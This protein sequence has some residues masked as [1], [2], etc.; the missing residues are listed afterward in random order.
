M[1]RVTLFR[2]RQIWMPT[3]YG[4]LALLF[5]CF[6]TGL[7][8]VN[9]LY[10]FLAPNNPSG[11]RIL[12]IEG[13]LAP[14]EL[15]QAIEIF[16]NGKYERIVTTGG[17]VSGWPG[18]SKDTSYAELAASYLAQHGIR[19]DVI[20]SVPA[21]RSAQERTFLSAV[22]FREAARNLGITLEAIDVFSSG[23]HARRSR[24][25]FQM[26]LGQNVRVGVLAARPENFN[27][28]AWWRSSTGVE[29]MFFQSFAYVWVKCCFWPGPHG[30]GKEKWA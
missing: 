12:V 2:Q 6:V 25:L 4:W 3:I 7:L 28:D 15:D 10:S 16:K 13:W 21:P 24:L 17:P 5:I 29:Q 8:L 11:A 23:P 22:M 1:K 27:P 19:R 26:A 14:E 18:V 9:S 20:I 30:S